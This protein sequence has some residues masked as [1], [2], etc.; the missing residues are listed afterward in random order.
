M[1]QSPRAYLQAL[2]LPNSP[3]VDPTTGLITANWYRLISALISRTGG[4]VG[5]ATAE[6]TDMLPLSFGEMGDAGVAKVGLFAVPLDAPMAGANSPGVGLPGVDLSPS[7]PPPAGR[8]WDVFTMPSILPAESNPALPEPIA[9]GPSPF[10]FSPSTA[11]AALLNSGG[12]VTAVAITRDGITFYPSQA[13]F[14]MFPL[15]RT[16][17]LVIT[18]IG[19]PA[20]TFFPRAK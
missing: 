17:S 16:D 4:T 12:G 14:G 11:G 3:V 8:V 2:P 1:S 15:E 6:I 20:L 18:Y 5:I 19:V 9:V 7:Y 13:L 10:T